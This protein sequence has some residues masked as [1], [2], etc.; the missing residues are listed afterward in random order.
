MSNVDS[1]RLPH[2]TKR[3]SATA[4]RLTPFV[5]QALLFWGFSAAAGFWMAVIWWLVR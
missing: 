1:M 3:P 2:A 5:E 4:A